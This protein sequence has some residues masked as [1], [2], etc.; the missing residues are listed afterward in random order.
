MDILIQRCEHLEDIVFS[1]ELILLG[2]K[3]GFKSDVF[4]LIVLIGKL[5][6]YSCKFVD[7]VPN[8]NAF[9]KKLDNRYTIDRYL[10]RIDMNYQNF[11]DKWKPYLPLFRHI[12]ITAND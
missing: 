11:T 7:N 4:D 8:V 1:E 9:I 10:A 5:Y 6:I 12:N 2:H 3:P